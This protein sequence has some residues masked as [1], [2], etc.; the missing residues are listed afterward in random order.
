[1]FQHV[2]QPRSA[3]RF[4][5]GA[6]QVKKPAS[7]RW[8]LFVFVK[9]HGKAIWQNFFANLYVLG[10]GKRYYKQGCE[11]QNAHVVNIVN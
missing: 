10:K 11:E 8:R 5:Y 1:V 4:I 7:H 9:Q 6:S 2:R 3:R